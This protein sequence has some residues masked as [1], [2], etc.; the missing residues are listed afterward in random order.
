MSAALAAELAPSVVVD[1]AEE[2]RNRVP[3]GKAAGSNP[4]R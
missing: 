3:T 1:D 2:A 4:A